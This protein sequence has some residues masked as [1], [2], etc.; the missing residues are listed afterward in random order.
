MTDLGAAVVG[1]AR[2]SVK[3]M[4]GTD[5]QSVDIGLEGVV[6][7]RDWALVDTRTG[8]L[9]SAKR[10]SALLHWSADDD[11]ITVAD[12]PTVR[13]DDPD[14]NAILSEHLGR[15]VELHRSGLD[16]SLSYE[17]TFEP[18]NDDAE[19]IAIDAP[20]GR[21]VDLAPLHVVSK[22]TLE[23]CAAACPDL[24]WDVRRFRPNLVVDAPGL[25]PF[26][27]DAW[28]GHRLRVG[29][30]VLEPRQPTVRC[31]MPLRAQ[32][33]LDRQPD[34]YNALEDLH[35][36]HLGIYVWV[37]QPGA[38]ALGDEVVLVG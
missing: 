37:E 7:D 12:G 29:G 13:F 26:G 1:L 27:E 8:R 10:Y 33:T 2:Y 3:S 34:L 20:P 32:P 30:A 5:C 11:G 38:V 35:A 9:M 28:C 24:N 14:I 31:A 17:M 21:F 16:T 6:G 36:N 19:Y 22:Q 15:P 23:G 4:Q 25:E 18:P